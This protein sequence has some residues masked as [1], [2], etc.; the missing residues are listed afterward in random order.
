M[1]LGQ[2]LAVQVGEVGAAEEGGGE[3][4]EE[5]VQAGEGDLQRLGVAG[6]RLKVT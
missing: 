4:G 3:G 6:H 1:Q 2:D 5:L